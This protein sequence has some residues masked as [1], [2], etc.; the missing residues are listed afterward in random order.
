[1]RAT[2]ERHAEALENFKRAIAIKP[3]Y[4]EA[5]YSKGNALKGLDRY[6]EALKSYDRAIALPHL[7]QAA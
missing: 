7:R 3:D 5:F 4:V 1:M 6:D 2:L